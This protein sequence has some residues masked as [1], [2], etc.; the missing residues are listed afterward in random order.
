[1]SLQC[2]EEDRLGANRMKDRPG[3]IERMRHFPD[4]VYS[5]HPGLFR[6]MSDDEIYA[7]VKPTFF[8]L[9]FDLAPN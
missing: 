8:A 9:P 6:G 4:L 2:P 7:A 3:P 5:F 1:M